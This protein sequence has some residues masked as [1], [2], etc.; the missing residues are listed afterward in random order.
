M[1]VSIFSK[2]GTCQRASVL[3]RAKPPPTWSWMPPDAIRS[4]VRVAI[5]SAP[6]L[7]RTCWRSNHVEHHR[8]RELRRRAEAAPRAIERRRQRRECPVRERIVDRGHSVG[9]GGRRDACDRVRDLCPLGL[10]FGAAL[11]PCL[12]DRLEHLPER[13]HPVARRVREVGPRIEGPPGRGEEDRHRPPARARHRLDG[14]HVDRVHVRPLFAVHLDR[15]EPVVQERRPY[16]RPRRTRAPSRGTNGMPRSRPIGRS[17][18]LASEPSRT[19][20]RPRGTSRPD[21][22]RAGAGTGSWHRRG[23]STVPTLGVS[24]FRKTCALADAPVWG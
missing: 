3:Y 22:G 21:C 8:L 13:R 1:S 24:R 18:G 5:S 10:D 16:Q 2:C 9:G 12:G 14:V 19:P 6:L 11:R 23:G 4:R 7:P 17:A 15:D 20:R